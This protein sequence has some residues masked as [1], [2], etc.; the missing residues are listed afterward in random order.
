MSTV[1]SFG[2]EV[3]TNFYDV[4]RNSI[5]IGGA[6]LTYTHEQPGVKEFRDAFAPYQPGA[7]LHQWALEGWGG[8]SVR[9]GDR[10]DGPRPDP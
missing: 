9:R 6:S 10:D 4:C 3:G 8:P 7:E 2:D 1:V 5:Y